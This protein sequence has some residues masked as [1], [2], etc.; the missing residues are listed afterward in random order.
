MA[1]PAM[2]AASSRKI[3]L[4]PRWL[5]SWN[6]LTNHARVLL[7]IARD[8]GVR[9]RDVAASLGITERSAYAIVTDLAAAGY[10]VKQKHGRRNRY[11]IQIQ[12]HLPLVAVV[13]APETGR[14]VIGF[15]LAFDVRAW[16]RLQP[17]VYWP[18]GSRYRVEADYPRAHIPANG[19]AIGGR[20]AFPPARRPAQAKH[21]W[22]RYPGPQAPGQSPGHAPAQAAGAEIKRAAPRQ[23]VAGSP[24][25]VQ[26]QILPDRLH[27]MHAPAVMAQVGDVCHWELPHQ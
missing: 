3:A 15:A 10:V 6:F 9:L 14:A 1:S 25:Q 4:P 2:S 19:R 5:E 22:R 12:M 7:C 20:I 18:V 23:L 16:R 21:G 8:P 26:H 11:Q 24:A 13:Q 27:I 17:I